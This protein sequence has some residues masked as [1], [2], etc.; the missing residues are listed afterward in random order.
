MECR[1]SPHVGRFSSASKLSFASGVRVM[2]RRMEVVDR[3]VKLAGETTPEVFESIEPGCFLLKRPS[4]RR[5]STPGQRDIAFVTAFSALDADPYAQEWRIAPIRKRPENPYPDRISVGRATNCDVVLRVHFISKVHAHI[6][7][8]PDGTYSLR[9]NQAV[10][11]TA[12]NGRKLAAGSKQPLAV[13]DQ[14]ALGA[15][16]FE[17]VDSKRLHSVLRSEYR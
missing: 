12:C 16:E 8:E 4:Q 11:P 13:G 10:A 3:Y 1:T 6:L 5:P 9:D 14:I 7:R 2:L 17:F 15:L